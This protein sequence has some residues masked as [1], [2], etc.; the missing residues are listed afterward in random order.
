MPGDP[1]LP[2]PPRESFGPLSV[3][4][5]RKEDGRALILYALDTAERSPEAGAAAGVMDDTEATPGAA[6]QESPCVNRK[7]AGVDD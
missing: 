1:S 2:A 4:R 5:L 6:P 3:E 7:P